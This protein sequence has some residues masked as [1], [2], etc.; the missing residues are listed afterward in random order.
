MENEIAKSIIGLII[1]IVVGGLVQLYL[2]YKTAVIASIWEKR[3][4]GYMKFCK[5]TRY[6]PLYPSRTSEATWKDVSTTSLLFKQ[7]YFEGYGLLLH[8]NLRPEYFK[9]QKF[10]VNCLQQHVDTE[11]KMGDE[12]Y[13]EIRKACS[14]LRTKMINAL[15]IRKSPILPTLIKSESGNL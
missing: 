9:L 13:E 12:K 15:E 7:W 11:E 8:Q 3:L 14:A 2:N 1:T 4:E 10:L 5:A 6:F